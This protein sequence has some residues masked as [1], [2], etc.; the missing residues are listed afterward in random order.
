MK[1]EPSRFY[2]EVWKDLHLNFF[3]LPGLS[4]SR[5]EVAVTLAVFT[6]VRAPI[7][8]GKKKI[9]IDNLIQK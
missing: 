9:E 2:F 3:L 6:C 4:W 7:I 8:S 1:F 5:A